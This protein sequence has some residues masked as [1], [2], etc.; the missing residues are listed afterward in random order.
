MLVQPNGPR[1]LCA[2][3]L[4]LCIYGIVNWIVIFICHWQV[5][6]TALSFHS[7]ISR[8]KTNLTCV[9]FF[10]GFDAVKTNIGQ[11]QRPTFPLL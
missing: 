4:H 3:S 6:L 8:F 11:H 9:T 10:E 1:N 2:E 7:A 5:G